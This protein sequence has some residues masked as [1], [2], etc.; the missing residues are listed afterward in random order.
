VVEEEKGGE[1]EA[2]ANEGEVRGYFGNHVVACL[3]GIEGVGG[4]DGFLE[5][6]GRGE[7]CFEE[8]GD[9]CL[10]DGEDAAWNLCQGEG[11]APSA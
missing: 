6:R 9:V 10:A 7:G 3:A 8:E 11:M 1:G 2:S 4:T 5:G